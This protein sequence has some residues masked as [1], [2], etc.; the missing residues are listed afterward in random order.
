MTLHLMFRP[1]WFALVVVFVVIFI[2]F[3]SSLPTLHHR[4]L[5]K[6][7][8][9]SGGFSVY[10]KIIVSTFYASWFMCTKS[11]HVSMCLAQ[12]ALGYQFPAWYYFSFNSQMVDVFS[13][14]RKMEDCQ[15]GFTQGRSTIDVIHMMT[16][17]TKK[18]KVYNIQWYIIF[19]DFRQVVDS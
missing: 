13:F 15:Y 8:F 19:I 11:L 7:G 6:I 10:C 17:V 3:W 18:C 1:L 4:Q 2:L 9:A 14:I 5:A 16:Y 12:C